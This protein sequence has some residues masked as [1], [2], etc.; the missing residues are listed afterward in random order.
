MEA[1]KIC[2]VQLG[3]IGDLI[4]MTPMFKALKQA[5][6]NNEI[7]LL[8]GK[9]NANFAKLIQNVD[10]VHIYQKN[11]FSTIK[12]LKDLYL[13]KFDIWIDPKDHKSTESEL[14]ATIIPATKKIGFNRNGNGPFDVPIKADVEQQD[15]HAL[16]RNLDV[17]SHF[18]LKNLPQRPI[19][20]L[21]A[22]S[23]IEFEKFLNANNIS[24]YVL[25]NIS[26][27]SDTRLWQKEHWQKLLDQL[28]N[29]KICSLVIS[30]PKD[31]QHA[32]EL[33]SHDDLAF[34]YKTSSLND[35]FSVINCAEL[36]VT[37]DTAVVHMAAVFDTP[38]VALY[39]NAVKNTIKFAPLSRIAISI[40]P[41]DKDAPVAEIEFDKVWHAVESIVR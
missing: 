34:F 35:V 14:F 18:K 40:M 37:P 32:I 36:L 12:L 13:Q 29:R 39:N 26:A 7:H 23:E 38:I 10:S 30:D 19:L 3:R 20:A 15:V 25:V 22:E 21:N 17:L 41:P 28:G 2:I 31:W 11:F 1:Q 5:N 24:N 4:L 8:A 16:Q 33:T 9:H 27:S 6:P